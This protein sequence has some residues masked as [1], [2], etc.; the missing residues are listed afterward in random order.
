MALDTEGASVLAARLTDRV[1]E[2]LAEAIEFRLAGELGEEALPPEDYAKAS[3]WIYHKLG[4]RARRSE[5]TQ[6]KK[7]I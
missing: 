6:S 4:T 7:R 2:A 3:D 1:L 5:L